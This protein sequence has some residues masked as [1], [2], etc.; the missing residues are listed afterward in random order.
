MR[1][2]LPQQLRHL[3]QRMTSWVNSCSLPV[4]VLNTEKYGTDPKSIGGTRLTLL[5]SSPMTAPTGEKVVVEAWGQFAE[6]V[7]DFFRYVIKGIVSSITIHFFLSFDFIIFEQQQHNLSE[8]EY[9]LFF[10]G[11]KDKSTNYRRGIFDQ[12]SE[13]PLRFHQE[14]RARHCWWLPQEGSPTASRV[15]AHLVILP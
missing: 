6:K 4:K 8:E 1:R 15:H 10:F 9:T 11:S 7:D 13:K 5:F 3:C 14:T 12:L 2:P